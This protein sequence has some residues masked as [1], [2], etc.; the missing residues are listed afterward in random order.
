M[1]LG[2]PASWLPAAMA[3]TRALRCRSVPRIF[4]EGVIHMQSS[5]WHH[6]GQDPHGSPSLWCQSGSNPDLMA[7]GIM[8]RRKLKSPRGG[9]GL[10]PLF[11]TP[12]PF[13]GG[14][15][16]AGGQCSPFS[17]TPPFPC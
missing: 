6:G 8:A 15:L 5:W 1:A 4:P 9:G 12:P 11:Q 2:L 17:C 13:G 16:R 7:P 14:A 3:R 10:E